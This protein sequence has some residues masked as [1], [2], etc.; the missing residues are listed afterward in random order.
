VV[1]L[2]A[3]VLEGISFLRS[4]QQAKRGA[5]RR[6]IGLLSQVF[7]TSDPTLRAVFAEDAAALV[8]LGIAFLGILLH[9]LTGSPAYDSIGSILVGLLLGVVAVVLINQNRRFLLGETVD[10]S[11]R[12]YLLRRL[13]NHPD[14]DRVTYLHIE[15]A[16]PAELFVVAAIDFA[17]NDSENSLAR[18][19][20][21]LEN[22]LED[23]PR[24]TEAVLTLATPDEVS[25]PPE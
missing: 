23:D 5:T 8:G 21:R 17:G 18:T 10:P 4:Y 25:L 22:E 2:I 14:V 9:Q 20:R 13:L 24:V 16:G 12:Q 6:R 15:F 1:L 19:L 7:R 3:A 11:T